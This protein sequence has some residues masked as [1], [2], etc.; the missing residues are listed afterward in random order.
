MPIDK[1]IIGVTGGIGSGKSAATDHFAQLGI[2]VIDA[3]I[4]ARTVVAAGKPAL[5]AIA[6]HFGNHVILTNGELDR[7]QLRALVF[8]D[9]SERKWLEQLT[10]PLI[11]NEI[12]NGL[13]HANSPYAILSSPLLFESGQHNLTHR[14]LLI[15]VPEALQIER[16]CQRD[17]NNEAQVKAIIKAQMPRQERLKYADDII[18]NDQDLA[19]LH[20]QVEYFHQQ[21]LEQA[22]K[23]SI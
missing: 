19:Y 21:Y 4:A 13:S 1:L 16:T 3:D 6:K 15:D 23:W 14:N 22:K 10:H 2:E 18:C 9:E 11:R 12:I 7:A 8:A 5:E 17:S 20:S